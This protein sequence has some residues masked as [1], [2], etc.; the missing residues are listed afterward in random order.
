[1][2]LA[3][4]LLIATTGVTLNKHYCMG[5]LQSVAIFQSAQNCMDDEGAEPM[6]C[7]QDVSEELKLDEVAKASFEFKGAPDLVPM[8]I[9]SFILLDHDLLTSTKGQNQYLSYTPP[10]LEKDV[11]VLIQSFLI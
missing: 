4:L 11:P 1:M 5:R 9:V 3:V 10:A 2:N 8:A 7:C 6:P